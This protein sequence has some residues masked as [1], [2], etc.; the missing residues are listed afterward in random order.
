ML[1]FFSFWP[2]HSP[3]NLQ[4]TILIKWAGYV[5]ITHLPIGL[6]HFHFN[7]LTGSIP[8]PTRWETESYGICYLT[9]TKYRLLAC[10]L[11]KQWKKCI[12]LQMH[13]YISRK[14][15]L[16]KIWYRHLRM[17]ITLS[18]LCAHYSWARYWSRGFDVR[19]VLLSPGENPLP[20][21]NTLG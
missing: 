5:R 1:N 19:H 10:F 6:Q 4:C 7:I 14:S 16:R 12:K 11:H 20:A 9:T 18:F 17:T 2:L 15:K 13:S 3:N 21:K 8:L